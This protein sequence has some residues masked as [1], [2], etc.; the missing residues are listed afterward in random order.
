L[1]QL[2][3]R[4]ETGALSFEAGALGFELVGAYRDQLVMRV[5]LPGDQIHHQRDPERATDGKDADHDYLSLPVGQDRRRPAAD[6]DGDRMAG[7]R[8]Y[9]FDPPTPLIRAVLAQRR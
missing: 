8:A 7:E 9:R 1:Q 4:L 2:C 6:R 3:L 5:D